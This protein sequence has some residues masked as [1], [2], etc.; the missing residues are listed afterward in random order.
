MAV[1]THPSQNI[2]QYTV[3]ARDLAFLFVGKMISYG[4]N[5]YVY[6]HEFD[7]SLVLKYEPQGDEFQ[8]VL[9]WRIWKAVE[10]SK[11]LGPWFAPCVALSPNGVWLIQ[12]KIRIIPKE[13]YPKKIPD[14]I[15]DTSYLNFG[16]LGRRFVCCDYGTPSFSRLFWKQKHL[17]NAKWWGKEPEVNG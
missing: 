2:E 16:M 11:T 17:T 4:Q 12:K 10:E 14:F 7:S 13:K 8:N 9:E 15:G 5:R 6:E 1:I 3:S